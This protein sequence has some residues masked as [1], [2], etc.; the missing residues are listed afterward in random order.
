MDESKR[1]MPIRTDKNGVVHVEVCA[2]GQRLHRVLPKGTSK[3]VAKNK[4]A[5]LNRLLESKPYTDD[6]LL[7]DVM[8][9]Y[10]THADTLR[11][12]ETAK[13]HAARI[14][15]YIVGRK[16]SQALACAERITAGLRAEGYKPA[17][18]NRSLGALTKALWLAWKKEIIEVNYG[19]K[20]ERLEENNERTVT[21]TLAEV[22][23]IADKASESVKTA[24]WIG[25]YTGMRRG[26]ILK[27]DPKH[28]NNGVITIPAGNTKTLK[29]RTV[30]VI[31]PVKPWLEK[32]PL[33]INF[34][35]L[36]SGFGRARKAANMEHVNFHDLRR[37][38]GSLMVQAGVDIYVVSRI[39]GH[40]SVEVTQRVYAHLKV[41][42]MRSGLEKAFG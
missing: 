23:A 12:P 33:G 9:L 34:E 1:I 41:E 17:T 30:P 15:P 18:I 27:L 22:K 31:E 24:I 35:G 26:E 39:L 4:E 40:S 19:E 11:S 10:M 8:A 38:C 32:I 25:I 29:M 28:I 37:S 13:H 16:A 3:K 7:T 20:V 36:K 5:E 2:N 6:P 14:A 21:V 42:Q